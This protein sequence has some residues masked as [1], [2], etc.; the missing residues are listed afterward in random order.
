MQKER[1]CFINN[2][3]DKCNLNEVQV[4]LNRLNLWHT[5]QLLDKEQ[6]KIVTWRQLK[7]RERKRHIGR[8]AKWFKVIENKILEDKETREIKEEYKGKKGC[9]VQE[10]EKKILKDKKKK[11]WFL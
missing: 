9:Q 3:L 7:V 5:N 4:R 10:I 6:E 1:D 11:E 8:K 2:I